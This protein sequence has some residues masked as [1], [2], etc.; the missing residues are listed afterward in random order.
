MPRL[1]YLLQLREKR[2]KP[3]SLGLKTGTD[4]RGRCISICQDLIRNS[5]LDLKKTINY[6]TFIEKIYISVKIF[7]FNKSTFSDEK[8]YVKII[9][10][11]SSW[12]TRQLIMTLF[13]RYLHFCFPFVIRITLEKC[14]I[15]QH[16]ESISF[17]EWHFSLWEIS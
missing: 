6:E 11:R 16:L 10:T 7:G 4:H 17:R 15:L 9:L 12:K 8:C 1:S 2:F 14:V 5:I 3:R 13:K